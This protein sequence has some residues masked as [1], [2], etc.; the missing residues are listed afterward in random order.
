MRTVLLFSSLAAALALG[1][2]A[3]NN[4][5]VCGNGVV[6]KG[7]DCDKADQNGKPGISCSA[8][9]KSISVLLV[10]LRVTWGLLSNLNPPVA[11]YRG[12]GCSDFGAVKARVQIDGPTAITKIVNCSDNSFRYLNKC[13]ATPD[14]GLLPEC[15]LL[16]PGKYTATVTLLRDD[17]SAL[18][19]SVS[20]PAQQVSAG[21][22]VPFPIHFQPEDF[23][24]Q[25][26]VGD[27]DFRV[28]WGQ[29]RT[30][31]AKATPPVTSESILLFR[32]GQPKPVAGMTKGGTRLDGTPG[33]CMTPD[34]ITARGEK[35]ENLPW[36]R[37]RIVVYS[38][39][40]AYCGSTAV[41]VHPGKLGATWDLLVPSYTAPPDGGAGD[42]G[43]SDGGV[44]SC[45]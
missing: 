21:Q 3:A 44:K 6:E 5:P 32:E 37:Y 16:E 22:E 34:A 29:E 23:L 40:N 14:G 10:Q 33:P 11:N 28:A 12:A 8:T 15:E 4:S 19:S 18:T 2:T 41:F 9:C 45:P 36:G 7:E 25:D 38:Q 42:G 1:C 43:V 20:Y 13:P 24:K 26:Y 17:L 30:Y 35:I 27:L 31:C 39:N